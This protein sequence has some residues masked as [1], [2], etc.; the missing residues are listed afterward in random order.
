MGYAL[1]AFGVMF[2]LIASG[3]LL[4]F[5]REAMLQRISEVINPATKKPKSLLETIQQTGLSVGGVVERFDTFLP[6]SQAEVSIVSQRLISAG[7]RKEG[8]V[9]L[10]YGS[11]VLVPIL[12]AIVAFATGLGALAP[13]LVYALALGLGFL[14][15][16]FW[17]GNRIKKRQKRIRLGLPDVLDLLIICIEAGLSLDQATA[18]SA[19]ELRRAQ[20]E[21]CDELYVVVLEQRAGRPRADCWRNMADRTGVDAVRNLVSMLIQSEQLGTSVARTLRIHSDTLRTQRVQAVEEAAAKLTIKLLFPLVFFIFPSLFLVVLGPAI[22][23]MMAGFG[24][25]AH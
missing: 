5:Y 23:Q 13:L 12:L 19:E 8:T 11:K 21:L 24:A 17:L 25:M 3:G 10:L 4:L 18:R 1:L 16:D 9:K 22:I 6:K 14:I 15:P 20:P 7:Y 2:L